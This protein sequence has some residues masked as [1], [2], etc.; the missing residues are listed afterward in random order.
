[1]R[2]EWTGGREVAQRDLEL[3]DG[4]TLHVLALDLAGR[5]GLET[6]VEARDVIEDR[7]ASDPSLR[8][9]LFVDVEGSAVWLHAWS[10][11]DLA[12]VERMI[13]R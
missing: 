11:D 2:A 1:M 4:R 7:L 5:W 3:A 8:E 12:A 10:L 13:E 6:N 9:R